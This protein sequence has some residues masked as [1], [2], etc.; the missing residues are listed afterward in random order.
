MSPH[1]SYLLATGGKALYAV[2]MGT[3]QVRGVQHVNASMQ[4]KDT[5][6]EAINTQHQGSLSPLLAQPLDPC[7][8]MVFAASAAAQQPA[9]GCVKELSS[10]PAFTTTSIIRLVTWWLM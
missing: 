8:D 2:F 10:K 9:A 5:G 6:Q 4:A 3:K 7:L 1:G